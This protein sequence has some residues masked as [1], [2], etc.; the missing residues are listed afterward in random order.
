[1]NTT[2]P[3][4]SK[5][6]ALIGR[7]DSGPM[8]MIYPM[9][10]ETSNARSDTPPAQPVGRHLSRPAIV[11]ALILL[12]PL[13][14][15]WLFKS[16]RP[17]RWEKV[18]A[19]IGFLPLF[20]VAVLLVLHPYWDF[21]GGMTLSGFR[22]DFAKGGSQFGRLEEHR[23]SQ[24][25][26]DAAGYSPSREAL[27]LAWSDFRGPRRDGVVAESDISLDW[28]VAPPKELW[29]QPVGEGYASFVLGNGRA[30]TIEQRR[31][32]EAITCYDPL[33]GRELWV[34]DYPASF[35]ETLGGNGPRSTPT[36]RDDRLYVLGAAGD[37][38]CLN[39][40][41][42]RRI[43]HRNILTE[44]AAE[45]LTWGM[46]AS[47]LVLEDKVVVTSSGKA[48]G[49]II[50]LQPAT[51]ELIWQTNAGQQ[52]YSSPILVDLA[53]RRQILNLAATSLNGID[54]AT[55][56]VLWSYPWETQY[57]INCSQPIPAGDDR[58]FVSSGY[59]R[60]S[61]LVRIESKDGRLNPHEVW[62]NTRLKSKF[63]SSVIHDGF[64]YGLNERVLVCLDLN[65][66]ERRWRGSRY[67][68]GSLLL[69][70]DHILV[71]GERG[72]LA[73]VKADPKRFV[74]RG[75][76]Q[77]FEGRTWNNMALSGGLLF[78]RNHREMVCYD[79]REPRTA[80]PT[81]TR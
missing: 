41:T 6:A 30:Y 69:V 3:P 19:A 59:G 80:P 22:F 56:D 53:G 40:I 57:G 17:R 14:L 54:P 72:R 38:N 43:W 5:T 74:E 42:G 8:P 32:R 78:A 45:N 29:R 81:R 13:G 12:Y 65:T 71:L 61:A 1:M 55:G 68:Y 60:G 27:R 35:E 66:G 79:L 26:L 76:M 7:D 25:S 50:A 11:A 37:L 73:L 10:P 70:G 48:G 24:P 63:A 15:V 23:R 21:G 34:Y 75:A 44:W 46:S 77:V 4:R 62:S 64:I 67:D 39:A 36:L 9:A 33:T 58:V 47:P 51:G 49:S 18:A 52:A 28:Q 31:D 2:A 16:P 20:A